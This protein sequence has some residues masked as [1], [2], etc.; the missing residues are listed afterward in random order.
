MA[1]SQDALNPNPREL[2]SENAEITATVIKVDGNKVAVSNMSDEERASEGG[3]ASG[4]STG[5]ASAGLGGSLMVD[6]Q[7]LLGALPAQD[8]SAAPAAAVA[9]P[10]STAP[11]A[12][13]VSDN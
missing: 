6:L 1:G 5:G 7:G 2:V 10:G 13:E 12:S 4:A 11:P 3:Q 9:A 8:S